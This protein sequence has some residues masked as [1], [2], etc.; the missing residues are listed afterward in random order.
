MKI[1]VLDD[2]ES[3]LMTMEKMLGHLGHLVHCTRDPLQA[4]SMVEAN[5]YDFALVDY[6]M[7]E[8]NGAWFLRKAKV[9]RSTKVLLMTGY[10][11]R[12]AINEMFKLGARGYLIKPVQKDELA[13]HLLF[14]SESRP[15]ESAA[16][17]P[18]ADL[19]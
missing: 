14:H 18:V 3:I 2:E 8:Y 17:L 10:I 4:L 11:N 1:L 5:G 12:E 6:V 19:R 16:T 7:P 9:P 13:M 15:D